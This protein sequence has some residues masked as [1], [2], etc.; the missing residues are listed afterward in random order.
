HQYVPP[1]GSS[2]FFAAAPANLP[3]AALTFARLSLP[4]PSLRQRT[5][6]PSASAAISASQSSQSSSGVLISSGLRGQTTVPM[7]SVLITKLS[8]QRFWVTGE[9]LFQYASRKTAL[10]PNSS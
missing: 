2:F 3:L 7:G 8:Y 10:M 4:R 9:V 6:L 5:S 1:P